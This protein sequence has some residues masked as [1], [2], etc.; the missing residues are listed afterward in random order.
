MIESVQLP[1]TRSTIDNKTQRTE[2]NFNCDLFRL[3][4]CRRS[5][6]S[7]WNR[8]NDDRKFH[9]FIPLSN[10]ECC[11][12]RKYTKKYSLFRCFENCVSEIDRVKQSQFSNTKKCDVENNNFE[13]LFYFCFDFVHLSHTNWMSLRSPWTTQ[14]K[15]IAKLIYKIHFHE[16]QINFRFFEKLLEYSAARRYCTKQWILTAFFLLLLFTADFGWKGNWCSH[17]ER[18]CTTETEFSSMKCNENKVFPLF[19]LRFFYSLVLWPV[20]NARAR[21]YDYAHNVSGQ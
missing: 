4:L 1:L 11:Q 6:C 7:S 3:C 19:Y 13:I 16:S 18:F 5:L 10:D 20:W 21:S 14:S 8:F 9:H 12:W 2:W 17:F 15:W